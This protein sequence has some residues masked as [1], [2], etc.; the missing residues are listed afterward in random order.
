MTWIV[1]AIMV[2]VLLAQTVQLSVRARSRWG[3]ALAGVVGIGGTLAGLA[4]YYQST[5]PDP[6]QVQRGGL[7]PRNR[8]AR[9]LPEH[10]AYHDLSGQILQ[11]N[12]SP[13]E[14]IQP[15]GRHIPFSVTRAEGGLLISAVIRS[16]DQRIVAIMQANEWVLNP[17][18]YFR[19]SFDA[20][21]IEVIDE[22]GLPA[23][24]VEYIDEHTMRYGG[25]FQTLPKPVA[26]IYASFPAANAS[27][28][29]PIGVKHPRTIVVGNGL[30]T[31]GQPV[32]SE[33]LQS[34]L[35]GAQ[36]V[37]RPWDPGDR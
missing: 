32:G 7:M 10:G 29:A 9:E 36:G 19:K 22:Y 26:E 27:T 37:I 30:F 35:A 3:A 33:E 6:V 11:L 2:G 5:I 28:R 4:V 21:S 24:Q 14:T 16:L 12:I 31:W 8:E 17:N 23:L 13:G 34:F 18:Q 25:V 20:H 15:L 1:I